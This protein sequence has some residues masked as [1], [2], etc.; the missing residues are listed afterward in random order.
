MNSQTLCVQVSG[1]D[2]SGKGVF[3]ALLAHY[4][5]AAGIPLIVQGATT[6]NKVKLEKDDEVLLAKLL[7]KGVMIIITEIQTGP[8]FSVLS[9][10][11]QSHQEVSSAPS[12]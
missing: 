4:L 5:E 3:I 11:E 7:E 1:P 6:H 9:A 2:K 12:E 10:P 8:S